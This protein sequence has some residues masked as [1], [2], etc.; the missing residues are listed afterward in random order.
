MVDPVHARG[1]GFPNRNDDDED[2][3]ERL[4]PRPD[5]VVVALVR[6]HIVHEFIRTDAHDAVLTLVAGPPDGAEALVVG[7]ERVNRHDTLQNRTDH[8]A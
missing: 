6:G 4:A 3:R 5:V 7:V 8:R 2:V 1:R